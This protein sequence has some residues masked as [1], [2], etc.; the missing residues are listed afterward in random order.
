MRN[1][2]P[3]ITDLAEV[4]P[5]WLTGVLRHSGVLPA[6]EVTGVGVDAKP[7]YTST[8]ARLALTY[9]AGA[10]PTAPTRLFLKLARPA[11]TQRVVGNAQRRHEVEFHNRVA[12][13]M[14]HPLVVR[15]H[16]AAYAE[17]TGACHLLF[18]DVSQTHF[19]APSTSPP[20]LPRCES[21]M[22]AFAAFHAFWWDNA[23]LSEVASVP[24][25]ESVAREVAAI[26]DCYPGFADFAGARLSAPQRRWYDGALDALPRLYQRVADGR[27]RRALTLIHGD[28]NLSNV[29]LPRDVGHE[30]TLLIDW[31]LWGVSFAAEDLAH[32]IALYW[33]KP[34][35]DATERG[36]LKRY[37][38]GLLRHGV[39]GYTWVDCWADYRL[40]GIL[41]VLFMPMWFWNSG[42][43]VES[44]WRSL[45]SAMQAFEDLGCAQ[46]L[47]G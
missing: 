37:H 23:F 1:N 39:Q 46:L 17:E 20:N 26:R 3:V 43:P 13:M 8:V 25:P 42:A 33:P 30:Q 36:L 31:Q 10:P 18:D 35:R 4:T 45:G 40:A 15:C 9:S 44:V 14:P 24:T 47:A 19:T 7:T 5:A 38:E 16:H 6:G 22:D 21:A 34:V 27:N 32:L 11:S 2:E 29:M 28:A 12:A 41:R